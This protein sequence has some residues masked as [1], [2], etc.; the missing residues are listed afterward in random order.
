ML[1]YNLVDQSWL[2]VRL[3]GGEHTDVGVLEALL[4]ADEIESLVV[5]LPTQLPALMRQLLLPIV[6][7][8]LG[9]PADRNDWASR[10][11]AGA[12]TQDERERLRDYLGPNKHRSRF[13]LFD[14][15]VPFA[16]IACL[17]TAKNE[18]KGSALLVATTAT[19][20]NVP[21]FSSHTE[22]DPLP[23]TAAQAARWL[24]HTQCWDTAAIKT[25]AVGDPA[26]KSG[27]TTA[28][29]TSPLGHLGVVMPVGRNLYETLLLN[30]PIGNRITAGSPHWRRPPAGPAWETKAPDGLLDLWTWQSRRVR[31]IPEETPDGARVARVVL[32]AGDRLS[33]MPEWEPHTAWIYRK[34]PKST[35]GQVR[36]PRR[37]LPGRA[38]WR[39]LDALLAA[40]RTD[41]G[42]EASETSVLLE[43]LGGLWE[44]SKI[45][46]DYT[47][48]L[49]IFGVTYGTHSAVI[50][51]LIHDVI[52]LPIAALRTDS[53]TYHALLEVTRQAEDLAQAVNRLSADLRRAVGADPIPWDKGHR[54]GE[55]VLHALDPTVR[56]L[57]ADVREAGS[58]T[59]ALERNQ[60]AWELL[61]SRV[62]RQIVEPLFAATPASAFFGR[63]IETGERTTTYRLGTAEHGFR[64]RISQILTRDS[65]AR[66]R[67]RPAP[68]P[69]R[70]TPRV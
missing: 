62:T 41:D 9:P 5:D 14:P 43:Q 4:R 39:G 15:E 64:R 36:R 23:L 2:T 46:A 57:F 40:Q 63:E 28:N 27:K 53:D 12:F 20:N 49:E 52:P 31:L 18:T 37:H 6:L 42:E 33:A 16:Q 68:D 35:T 3:G 70:P 34:A 47:L 65:E 50:E 58:D 59:E 17:H 66:R 48:Q 51:D 7:D 44:A 60:L 67:N 1:T 30:L 38:I 11:S 10:F 19:G 13:D 45:P 54:P 56:R 25:G 29:P 26:V 55:L 8:A 32:S 21:L 69:A 24:L 61:A 22:G